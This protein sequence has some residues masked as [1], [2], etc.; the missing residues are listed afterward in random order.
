MIPPLC[1]RLGVICRFIARANEL[2]AQKRKAVANHKRLCSIMRDR[3]LSTSTLS[4]T[5]STPSA[6]IEADEAVDP[7]AQLASLTVATKDMISRLRRLGEDLLDQPT[8]LESQLAALA[9]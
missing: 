7:E 4:S 9:L 3:R 6:A 8:D 2:L 1:S 5:A